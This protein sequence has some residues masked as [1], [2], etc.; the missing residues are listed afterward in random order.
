MRVPSTAL[1]SLRRSFHWTAVQQQQSASAATTSAAAA[2]SATRT[3]PTPTT[4]TG[5][6]IRDRMKRDLKD[7]MRAKQ[8]LR[9]SAIKAALN[10]I[11]YASIPSNQAV[12]SGATAS[13]ASTS[14]ATTS[15]TTTTHQDM[16]PKYIAAIQ[17]M[18]KKRKDAIEQFRDGNRL[19]LVA[20]E[21]EELEILHAYV[22]PPLMTDHELEEACRAVI[23][24]LHV[25]HLRDMKR[26]LAE[27]KAAGGSSSSS[28][29]S[30]AASDGTTDGTTATALSKV[31]M[32]Q[33]AVM[34]KKLLS[35]PK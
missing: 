2:S 23:Q 21:T 1:L 5:S 8:S 28:S 27:V 13:S 18:I 32:E 7:A 6:S 10:E 35:G 22:P 29:S 12:S 34:V 14:S 31:P 24:R 33:V 26:V 30:S 4:T 17:K 19:D 3:T 16:E 25:T 11:A 15:T 9:Q 20:K